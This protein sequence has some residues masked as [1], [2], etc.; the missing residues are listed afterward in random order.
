M[1]DTQS[2]SAKPMEVGPINVDR[3]GTLERN[4]LGMSLF[5]LSEAVFFAVLILS[6]I[7][8][9][10]SPANADGPTAANSLNPLVSAIYTACLIASSGTIWLADR[11][12]DRGEDGRLRLW[13][14]ATV[15]LGG[16]FLFGQGQEYIRLLNAQVTVS[17]DLFGTTF[18]T[19][20]GFHGFHVFCGL[21]ALL[22]LFG[23]ALAGA[24][25]GKRASPA[26]TAISLYWHFVDVVWIVLFTIIY[27]WRT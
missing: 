22:I 26:V 5:L 19:L 13:L 9:R 8:F 21:V 20:T 2:S 25:K 23:L 1:D 27:I 3:L 15:A 24:F 4:R 18:F 11:A 16:V 14:L 17:R 10:D 6:Y 7:Y 12:L